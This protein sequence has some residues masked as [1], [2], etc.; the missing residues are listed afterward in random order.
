MVFIGL[1]KISLSTRI[2]TNFNNKSPGSETRSYSTYRRSVESIPNDRY[3][4]LNILFKRDGSGQE[5]SD[6]HLGLQVIM[7]PF[8]F[9]QINFW[10]CC[11]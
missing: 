11:V 4:F 5:Y 10:L 3:L 2:T 9:L 6:H 7:I 8:M 1:L